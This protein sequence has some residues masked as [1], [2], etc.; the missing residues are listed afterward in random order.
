MAKWDAVRKNAPNAKLTKTSLHSVYY[1]ALSLERVGDYGKA[2]QAYRS[3][4]E[5]NPEETGKICARFEAILARDYQNLTLRLALVDLLLQAGKL[6]E[7]LAQM[8][9]AME[10]DSASA[11]PEIAS[12][13]EPCLER[14]PG[15]PE[16]LWLL[17]R[18]RRAE[19]KYPEMLTAL[20]PLTSL[21]SHRD[22][23]IHLLEELT[24]KMEE[25]PTLRLALADAY[26][27]A[28]KPVLAVE[29]VLLASERLGDEKTAVALDKVAVAFPDHARTFLLLGE[30]DFKAGRTAKGVE[31]YERVLALSP[32]DGPILVPK[33]LSLVDPRSPSGSGPI[34]ASLTKIFL[35][36]GE[37]QSSG[38]P[39]AVQGPAGSPGGER[40]G[41]P[42]AGGPVRGAGPR[43]TSN[44]PGRVPGG[45]GESRG[46][47]LGAGGS[48]QG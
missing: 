45:H 44:G 25:H 30:L 2:A 17:A 37:R 16:P 22:R 43:G 29:A 8:E 36:M 41:H 46:S 18:A 33:L 1:V 20:S 10:G 19:G 27:A 26:M 28:G 35:R 4:I 39:V 31:R 34:C 14:H 9:Q 48:A 3:L 40:G 5:K 42:G 11:A 15:K 38:D 6:D 13:L 23:I 7:A 12:R 21:G 32:E 47:D 24:P